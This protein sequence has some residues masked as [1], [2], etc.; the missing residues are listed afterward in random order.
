MQ[1]IKTIRKA[2]GTRSFTYKNGGPSTIIG[3]PNKFGRVEYD[4]T[5]IRR[6]RN[7]EVCF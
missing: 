3:K 7:L 5:W 4:N 1:I 2:L 6:M